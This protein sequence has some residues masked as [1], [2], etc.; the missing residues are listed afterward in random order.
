M[1]RKLTIILSIPSLHEG[2]RPI[3][4][5]LLDGQIW[6]RRL[7]HIAVQLRCLDV[8]RWLWIVRLVREGEPV[9]GEIKGLILAYIMQS[10]RLIR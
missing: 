8:Q 7:C 5:K 10:G 1:H 2:V 6:H 4:I 3:R 9:R